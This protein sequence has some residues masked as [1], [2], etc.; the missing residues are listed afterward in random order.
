[1]N[2][3]VYVSVGLHYEISNSEMFGGEGS[4]GYTATNYGGVQNLEN[5]DDTFVEKQIELVA[6]MLEVSK[7]EV[8]LISK[9]EFDLATEDSDRTEIDFDEDGD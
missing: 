7:E 3:L 9:E 4:V 6:A 5:V 1:M 2:P 8:K